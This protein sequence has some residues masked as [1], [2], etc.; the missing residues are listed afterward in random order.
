MSA[1]GWHGAGIDGA[2]WVLQA[3][4]T[5]ITRRYCWYRTMAWIGGTM[6]PVVE[7]GHLVN[8]SP[9]F[10]QRWLDGDETAQFEPKRPR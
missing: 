1:T 3:W 9:E 8:A 4:Q 7:V 6:I 2:R 10:W 5:V